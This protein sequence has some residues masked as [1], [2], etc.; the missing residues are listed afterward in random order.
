MI[1]TGLRAIVF[2]FLVAF[3]TLV[4]TAQ[5]HAQAAQD[6]CA[7]GCACGDSDVSIL[8]MMEAY[9]EGVRVRDRAYT[10]QM[11]KQNDNALGMTCF[12]RALALTS[13]LG[14]I[15]S[16][17]L[18]GFVL[19]PSTELFGPVS[20]P[21]FGA[22]IML[23]RGLESVL[24][25]PT[26][27]HVANFGDSLSAQLGATVSGFMRGLVSTYITPIIT[28]INALMDQ[29]Y[30][31]VE[32]INTW[33]RNIQRLLRYFGY[34]LPMFM[35]EILATINS[36][37]AMIDQ[38]IDALTTGLLAVISGIV[39]QVQS[40]IQSAITSLLSAFNTGECARLARL[41]NNAA[42]LVGSLITG[43]EGFRSIMGSGLEQGVPYFNIKDMF[44]LSGGGAHFMQELTLGVNEP[45]INRLRGLY[46]G[47]NAPLMRPGNIP[48]WT[49]PPSF[50]NDTVS[51]EEILNQIDQN[52]HN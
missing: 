23:L 35:I 15:F 43:L 44:S 29:V 19:P 42:S 25:E 1:H 17:R 39:A 7:P 28:Q 38:A 26:E 11:V 34:A 8:D 46:E 49:R 30:S 6:D 9:S 2:S 4:A 52:A 32:N 41:W 40:L 3:L 20:Y 31:V 51:S 45:I 10:R 18:P 37:W 13:R 36:I 5:G 33:M 12:D 50:S 24:A 22:S 21:D 27:S 47:A 48:S 14:G 16:D